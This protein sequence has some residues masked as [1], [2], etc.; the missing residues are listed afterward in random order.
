M[1]HYFITLIIIQIIFTLPIC[2]EGENHCIKCNPIT[3]FCDKC[4]LEIYTPDKEGGCENARNCIVGKNNCLECNEEGTLCKICDDGYFPDENGA[5]SYTY[6]CVVSYQGKCIK[7]KNGYILIG[8]N[9]YLTNPL[10]I[11]KSQNSNDLKNCE[12]VNTVQGICQQCK[13]GFYLNS[14][15]KRCLNI[16]NC[17]E[18]TFGICEK[19]TEGFY[20]DKKENKCISQNNT[21][22]MTHCQE[23][24]DSITCNICEENYF[25]DKRGLCT[26]TNF[27]SKSIV[28]ICQECIE[29]YF[30][31]EKKNSCTK[32]EKFCLSGKKDLGVC[33]RCIDNYYLDYKDEKCKS[34][35][36][37]NDYKYC[38][39]A[40]DGK[41]DK[42]IQGYFLGEDKKCSFTKNCAESHF[43]I[44]KS[45]IKNYYLGFDNKCSSVE[46]CIYTSKYSELDECEECIDNYYFEKNTQ[47]CILSEGK[48]INCK[49]GYNDLYCFRCKDNFYLNLIDNLCYDNTNISDK[50]YKCMVKDYHSDFCNSC[51]EGYFIG[52]IDHKCSLD[53]GCDKS[54]NE[55]I[56]LECKNYYCL[57]SKTGKCFPNNKI[58]TEEKKTL[59]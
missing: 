40:D 21:I 47:K 35:I 33:E 53:E 52:Y 23:S 34:N 57:D 29:G 39:I 41:C 49:Y 10:Q 59:L 9:Q 15:D 12:I 55:N 56:C 18:S 5:C 8:N 16:E 44:C 54:E 45:C 24:I 30:L 51:I 22:T 43:G 42:C 32:T 50:F 37:D 25:F 17:H 26:E 31:T 14:G 19:C 38:L 3:K 58:I 27:C 46:N 11:C 6:N 4:E 1:M 2:K 48:Y 20:L 7:C 36:E 28:S 13:Q